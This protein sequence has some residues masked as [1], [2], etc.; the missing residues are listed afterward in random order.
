MDIEVGAKIMSMSVYG[1]IIPYAG[2]WVTG[3][4][5]VGFLLYGKLELTGHVCQIQVPSRAEIG[6][7]KFP[8][9]LQ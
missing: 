6:F 2:V 7:S 1:E 9:A 8:L 4:M 5:G 3:Y